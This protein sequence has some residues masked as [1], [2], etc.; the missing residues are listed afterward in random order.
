MDQLD[1]SSTTGKR[2]PKATSKIKFKAYVKCF[3]MKI[4][5][6]ILWWF[7]SANHVEKK[8]TKIMDQ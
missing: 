1:C 6:G 3:C 8:R 7:F 5:G 4:N 2:Q